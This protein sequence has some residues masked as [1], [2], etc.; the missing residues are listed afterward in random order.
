MRSG[1]LIS[2]ENRLK[3]KGK[4]DIRAKKE[5]KV[6]DT[7]TVNIFVRIKRQPA[8]NFALNVYNISINSS[9]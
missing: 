2:K 8:R 4:F 1:G 6:S 9:S 7:R 5:V 3:T